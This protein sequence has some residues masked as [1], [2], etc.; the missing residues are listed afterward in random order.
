MLSFNNGTLIFCLTLV[1][2]LHGLNS[3]LVSWGVSVTVVLWINAL[4]QFY[5]ENNNLQKEKNTFVQNGA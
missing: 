5:R 1:V 3:Q 2:L 4:I